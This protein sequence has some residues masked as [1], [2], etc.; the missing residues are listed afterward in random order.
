VKI[1]ENQFTFAEIIVKVKVAPLACFFL[2]HDVLL[3]TPS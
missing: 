3:S 1:F 2:R